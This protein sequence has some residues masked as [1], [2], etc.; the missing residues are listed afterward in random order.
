MKYPNYWHIDLKSS[1]DIFLSIPDFEQV[2]QIKQQ[3][4][5]PNSMPIPQTST[6]VIKLEALEIKLYDS[7]IWAFAAEMLILDH[8]SEQSE[9]FELPNLSKF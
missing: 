4:L 9:S 8:S 2:A 6:K 5:P 1:S 3:R 7:S